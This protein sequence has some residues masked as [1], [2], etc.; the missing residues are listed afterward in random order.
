MWGLNEGKL[1]MLQNSVSLLTFSFLLNTFRM[2]ASFWLTC[3]EK[4]DRRL[5]PVF[6]LLLWR[7]RF[8]EVLSLLIL[9]MEHLENWFLDP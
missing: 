5:L 8:S 7:R 1:K 2:A 6:S 4:V 9:L 3:S